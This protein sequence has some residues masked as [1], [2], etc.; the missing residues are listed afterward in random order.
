MA[1][2]AVSEIGVSLLL[3]VEEDDNDNNDD[4]DDE[5]SDTATPVPSLI[6]M[7]L[8]LNAKRRCGGDFKNASLSSTWHCSNRRD[9]RNDGSTAILLSLGHYDYLVTIN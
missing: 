4:D 5:C 9:R 8:S 2:V 1:A 7:F 6:G 3:P